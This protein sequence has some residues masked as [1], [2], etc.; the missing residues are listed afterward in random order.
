MKMDYDA[1]EMKESRT[2]WFVERDKF[3][4][5]MLLVEPGSSWNLPLD[6]KKAVADALAAKIM[7]FNLVDVMLAYEAGYKAGILSTML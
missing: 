2:G 6:M 1:T 4:Q 3:R 5:E 7:E